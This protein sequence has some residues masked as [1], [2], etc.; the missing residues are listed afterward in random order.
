[1]K[2]TFELTLKVTWDDL[3]GGIEMTADGVADCIDALI[4]EALDP[5]NGV[6]LNGGGI[7]TETVRCIDTGGQ[8]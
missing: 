1:M 2:R 5:R 4:T 7:T 6:V 3:D 8:P